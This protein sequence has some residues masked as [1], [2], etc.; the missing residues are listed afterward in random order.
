MC[1]RE[2]AAG[3]TVSRRKSLNYVLFA[4]V[5]MLASIIPGRAA[6]AGWGHC[7]QCNCPQFRGN[8]ELCGNCGHQYG[9]HWN[10]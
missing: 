8:Q 3:E 6:K 5:A 9:D 2:R 7:D 1:T 4:G 10:S